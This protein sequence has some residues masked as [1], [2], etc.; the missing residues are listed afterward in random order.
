VINKT[1]KISIIMPS[2][3]ATYR[4][5][6][7]GQGEVPS[8]RLIKLDRDLTINCQG[9][10]T[11]FVKTSMTRT[12]QTPNQKCKKTFEVTEARRHIQIQSCI[13]QA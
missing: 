6:K 5:K 7:M 4:Q 13:N 1:R 2:M 9:K 11:P 12:I 10:Q 8:R 3:T